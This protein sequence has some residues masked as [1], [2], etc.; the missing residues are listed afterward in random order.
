MATKTG[1][2]GIDS[3]SWQVTILQLPK[4]YSRGSVYGFCDGH[5]VGHAEKLRSGSFGCW[6]PGGKPELLALEGR[7]FVASA[8]AGGD[9]IPGL[10][11]EQNG[12]MRAVVWT[13]QQGRLA[14]RVLHTT[15][16]DQTWATASG[17]GAVIGMGMPPRTPDGRARNVGV[18]WRGNDE[19]A[20]VAAD[21]DVALHA[22]DGTRVAG[23]VHG[24]AMLWPAPNAK[25]IDLSPKG[26]EM[27]EVQALDGELQVGVAFKGFR[28]RAGYWR[29]A[30]ASFTDLTP[31]GFQTSRADGAARDYQVGSIR[32]KD[33]TRGGSGGSDNRAVIWQ[34][35]PDRWFDLNALLPSSKYN[36]SSALAIAIRDDTLLVGGGAIRYEVNSPGTPHESH[37]VPV[38]HPVI[39]TARLT[40]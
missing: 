4:G 18:V 1:V 30:A 32:E 13:A 6:W 5:P 17:G 22:T 23:S 20:T 24:R 25:P 7:K 11:R 38:A 40:A 3:D 36:A 10:W 29:G 19:P 31:R 34:G 12:E 28:A 14:A 33:T 21:G 8:R 9:M 26:M 37:A 35:S 16:F 2:T 15:A 39:W 27:S